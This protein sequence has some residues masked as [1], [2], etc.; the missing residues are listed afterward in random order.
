MDANKAPGPD[1]FNAKYSRRLWGFLK[2]GIFETFHEFYRSGVLPKGFNSS[3]LTLILKKENSNVVSDY[4]LISLINT[5]M[6]IL[7]K[8]LANILSPKM[9]RIISE[10]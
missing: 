5:T 6:K 3:F 7:L 2:E 4:R 8:I 9:D 1:G 10:M